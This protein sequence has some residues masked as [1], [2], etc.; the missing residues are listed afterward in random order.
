[1]WGGIGAD[2]QERVVATVRAAAGV[3]A[4]MSSV[5]RG[6][7]SAGVPPAS[8]VA[9]GRS[10]AAWSRSRGGSPGQLRFDQT[11]PRYYDRYLDWEI[12]LLV[13]GICLPVFALSGFYNRWWRYVS[14]RDMWAALRGVVL[15]TIAVFLVFTLFDIHRASRARPGSGSSSCCSASPSWPARACS[16]GR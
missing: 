7:L 11:R 8:A 16:P 12:V 10:T 4:C 9:G 1:M 6:G 3:A 2:V 15:A 5:L 14:T 13:V